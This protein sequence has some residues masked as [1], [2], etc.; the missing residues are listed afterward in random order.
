[1]SEV[2]HL[3]E[4]SLDNRRTQRTRQPIDEIE[5]SGSGDSKLSK[6]VPLKILLFNLTISIADVAS[7]FVQGISLLKDDKLKNYGYGTIAINWV[8]GLAAA[9]HCIAYHRRQLGPAK[10]IFWAL[11]LS[12]FYPV[13]PSIAYMILLWTGEEPTGKTTAKVR[14]LNRM[15]SLFGEQNHPIPIPANQPSSYKKLFKNWAFW[16]RFA[17]SIAASIEAPLQ[18]T[19]QVRIKEI[20]ASLHH[21]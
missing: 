3:S 21:T 9:I 4:I 5:V 1:M 16:A 20:Y 15:S 19:F 2:F 7:D 6:L 8:P 17:H 14:K 12:L 11:I 13:L 18:F 10:T